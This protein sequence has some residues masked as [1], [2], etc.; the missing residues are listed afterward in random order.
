M[1]RELAMP[2]PEKVQAVADI[3]ERLEGAEAVFFTEY[4]GL[5]VKAVQDLRRS[6]RESGADYKVV[7]MTLAKLAA[8]EAGFEGLDEYLSGPTALAFAQSD[9][10]ATAKALKDFSK[11]N[12]VFVLKAGFLSGEILTPEEVS[13]LADIEPREVLLAM[14]AGAAKAPLFQAASMFSSFSRDAAS[15]FS[16]LMDKKESGEFLP[17]GGATGASLPAE[18][19]AETAADTAEE[20]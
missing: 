7:K 10:V 12:E 16:Q 8:G 11:G 13:R 14:I 1:S 18:E 6:L 19:P 9:P 15:M 2:T 20:E 17:E 5:T 3:R 4:R